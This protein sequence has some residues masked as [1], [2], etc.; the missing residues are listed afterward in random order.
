MKANTV[1]E[2]IKGITEKALNYLSLKILVVLHILYP[3]ITRNFALYFK[4]KASLSSLLRC[5]FLDSEIYCKNN[6]VI[7]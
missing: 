6:K 4:L 1:F 2:H 5:N 3:L 7:N